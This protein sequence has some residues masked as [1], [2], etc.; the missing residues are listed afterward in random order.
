MSAPANARRR[1]EPVLTVDEA[2][3]SRFRAWLAGRGYADRTASEWV[4]RVRSAYARGA[5]SPG[6]VDA[7]FKNL[8]QPSRAGFRQALGAFVTSRE[9]G[10]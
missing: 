6:E 4:R 3:L 9:A 5:R 2:D 7:V 8:S 1:P 10:G